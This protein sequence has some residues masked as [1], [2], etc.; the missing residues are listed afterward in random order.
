MAEKTTIVGTN[1][2]GQFTV[3]VPRASIERID[4]IDIDLVLQTKGG[5]RLILPGAAMEAMTATPPTVAFPDGAV[6]AADLL[7]AVDKVTTPP[8]S[9]P[10]MT[11][12]TQF[13]QKRT[14]GKKNLTQDGDEHSAAEQQAQEAQAQQVAPLPIQ[15]APSTVDKLIE[16]AE[17]M[18]ADIRKKAFE[19]APPSVYEPPPSGPDAPPNPPPTAKIPL[20]I[21]LS[22]GN[23]VG[24]SKVGN[25]YYGSGGPEGS[26]NKDGILARDPLQ[27]GTETLIG[28]GGD[29]TFYADAFRRDSGTWA[30]TGSALLN[31]AAAYAGLD[32]ETGKTAGAFY[33]AKEIQLNVAGYVRRA[34]SITVTGLPEGVYI[35]GATG[36]SGGTWTI[37]VGSVIPNA[38][39]LTLVYDVT[40][41]NALPDKDVYMTVNIVG[42]GAE[43]FDVTRK[44][45]LRFMEAGSTDDITRNS[46]IY[47]TGE[48]SGWS[49]IYVMPTASAPHLIDTGN[50]NNT[51][52]AGNSND[53][54]IGGSGKDTVYAFAG[55]DTILGGDGA[56]HIRGGAGDDWIYG[57][58]GSNNAANG[59]ILDGGTGTADWISFNGIGNEIS[60]DHPQGKLKSGKVTLEDWLKH[61]G[62]EI[63]GVTLTTDATGS[64][65]ATRTADG[66]SDD[67]ANIENVIGSWKNDTI[68]L[69][70]YNGVK[71]IIYGLD[72]NDALTGADGDDTLYGGAG[73]DVIR[74]N[75]GNDYIHVGMTG[76]DGTQVAGTG[77]D[78]ATTPGTP[79]SLS[80]TAHA[81]GGGHTFTGLSNVA[82]GGDGADTLVGG[83]GDD[84][85]VGAMNEAWNAG[86]TANDSFIGGDGKDTVD[87]ST[88]TNNLVIDLGNKV[89]RINNGADIAYYDSIERVITGS[90][91]D[92]IIGTAADE[93][94]WAGN[95]TNTIN[96]GGGNDTVFGGDGTDYINSAAGAGHTAHYNGG[97]GYNE[98]RLR[99][100]A[101]TIDGS[102]AG[103]TDRVQYNNTGYT[104]VGGVRYGVFVN[105]DTGNDW[106]VGNDGALTAAGTTT[107]WYQWNGTSMVLTAMTIDWTAMGIAAGA[108]AGRGFFGDAQGD[109]YIGTIERVL[110][111][112]YND[113]LIGNDG[114]NAFWG[115]GGNDAMY[116]L[117]GDDVFYYS[118]GTSN[119]I[120][121]GTSTATTIAAA[122]NPSATSSAFVGGDTINCDNHQAAYTVTLVMDG[123]LTAGSMT[124]ATGT[125]TLYGIENFIGGNS[126]DTINGS[127]ANNY[128][129]GGGGDDVINGYGGD[130]I[131]NLG[132]AY[133]NSGL[134]PN[135]G[136]DQA[137]GGAGSDWVSYVGLGTV[138]TW[139]VIVHLDTGRG[140]SGWNQY[141]RTSN[142]DYDDLRNFENAQGSGFADTLY[143]S[144]G[145]N[146]LWGMAGNDTLY[147][148]DGN[149]TLAGH[150]G[151]DEL[152]GG[153][154]NDILDGGAGND[155]LDGGAG[156]DAM[157]G[158]SGNDIYY[159]D[160]VGDTVTENA[161]E[162]TDT[163]YTSVD[164]TLTDNVEHLYAVGSTGL[165]LT[166]NALANTVYGSTGDD[167]IHG[168]DGGD[169]LYGGAGSDTFV[170]TAAQTQN[171]TVIGGTGVTSGPTETGTDTL[172][173]TDNWDL[174]NLN[175]GRL[176]SIE[177]IDL[178]NGGAAIDIDLFG[179]QS[180]TTNARNVINNILDSTT[181]TTLHL[182]L[183]SGD[184]FNTRNS[185]AGTGYAN[186]AGSQMTY[187]YGTSS[188][189][190][191]W[192]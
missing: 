94:F 104:T 56:D 69:S 149:D 45:I 30:T 139:G 10:A 20:Y 100:G 96:V 171:T 25:V 148:L 58:R 88:Y 47:I 160:N 112:G 61:A 17:S 85:F 22:E 24:V 137:D 140:V 70:A 18:D 152:Y 50:G 169:R 106:K 2:K 120:D 157:A 46:P 115:N 95:G 13:D 97:A 27:Y 78:V 175:S 125:V 36:T 158:G 133:T 136:R 91:D 57:G 40:K 130:D 26:A 132:Y 182:Y 109:R 183:D 49:D 32:V 168:S 111:S 121:G 1:D 39:T 122:N 188:I 128:L 23:V 28:S 93:E 117:A 99:A 35:E 86:R 156:A 34:D 73:D 165:T 8:T 143:G 80:Y 166:G 191:H 129:C 151:N 138:G 65:T 153:N 55:N 113:V 41:M 84:Y 54:V 81:N 15:G 107:H 173:V 59:G 68:D 74:G 71:H 79:G 92:Y 19:P 11:S 14:V 16:K 142:G 192:S 72:G 52:Y 53:I 119:Y 189:V 48:G 75:G 145:E 29:E 155:T 174:G 126:A 77:I 103:S 186:H 64:G 127:D 147:G 118:A 7:S 82:D 172:R 76:I 66:E 90:G 110:G 12:L 9:I 167:T 177:V 102:T 181:N 101:E 114:D 33:Y 60:A 159:V 98:Y 4:V 67:V 144:S 179:N 150:D 131:I 180:N 124:S 31:D 83:A 87:H 170:L 154:G 89:G 134:S 178:R 5:D 43:P 184:R 62:T 21:A 63:N 38:A 164:F 116:G 37:P 135:S 187:T 108:T 190:V 185:D 161:N 162:G 146:I 176:H 44:F 51:V 3:P 141:S 105:L 123:S 42:M 6:G 163:V